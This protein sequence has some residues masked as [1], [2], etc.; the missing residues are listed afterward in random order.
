MMRM[1]IGMTR[2]RR[3]WPIESERSFW[4]LKIFSEKVVGIGKQEALTLSLS[5]QLDSHFIGNPN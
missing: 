5:L 1:K 3:K 2:M 4:R